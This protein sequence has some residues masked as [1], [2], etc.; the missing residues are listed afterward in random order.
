MNKTN[1][2]I[3]KVFTF[4][5]CMKEQMS[6]QTDMMNL[7]MVQLHTLHY[8]KQ[9][10]GTPMKSLAE[11]LKVELPSATTIVEKLVKLSF[12]KRQT[13]KDDRRLVLLHL[14]PKGEELLIGAMKE[15]AKNMEKI[16]AYLSEKDK[17]DLS[18][19]FDTLVMAMEKLDEK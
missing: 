2:L 15:R 16:L 11:Y 18:R 13:D 8:I 1:S 3:E 19:I 12:V 4:L 14:T 5:R 7:S 6:L 9:N 10:P 17:D